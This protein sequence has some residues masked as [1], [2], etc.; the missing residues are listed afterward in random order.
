MKKT[1]KRPLRECPPR[2]GQKEINKSAPS[3][4]R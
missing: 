4:L 2:S 3:Q 1:K